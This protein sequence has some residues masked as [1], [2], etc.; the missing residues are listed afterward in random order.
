M[1]E[2][3]FFN[4]FNIHSKAVLL[5][6]GNVEVQL[7]DGT[8]A[9]ANKIDLTSVPRTKII[10]DLLRFFYSLN[11]QFEAENNKKIWP[12][13]SLIQNGEIFNGSSEHFFNLKITDEEF[14]KFKPVVGDID[15]AVPSTLKDQLQVFLSE[16]K[17]KAFT[18]NCVFLGSKQEVIGEGH[19]INCLIRMYDSINVQIDFELLEYV[20]GK[21]SEF[22]KFSHSSSWRDI[23]EGFKGVLHK[24]LIQSAA[25]SS[26]ILTDND[27]VVFTKKKPQI[28]SR[29]AKE[30]MIT[31]R[32]FSIDRGLRTDAYYHASDESGKPLYHGGKPVYRETETEQSTYLT[33]VKEIAREIFGQTFNL[34]DLN[35]FY[36]FGGVI[37]L[38]KKYMS[39]VQLL[40]IF[41]NF[42]NRLFGPFVQGFERNNPELDYNIKRVGYEKVKTEFNIKDF[43][44]LPE[45]YKELMSLTDQ[46]DPFLISVQTYYKN[47][48]M[49]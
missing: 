27:V 23:A 24:Y 14:V 39:D 45:T 7:K 9:R 15:V 41:K 25:S 49:S 29:F 10:N 36:S 2:I 35:E 37:N 1:L 4:Y 34:K 8:L 13:N 21:P 40:A 17:G 32:K 43:S 48:R 6:G 22:A 16:N 47:Y 12:D 19:Q 11:E 33:K 30:K 18:K 3:S 31:P 46:S 28:S 44:R 42:V 26:L 38:C 5:E 20:K